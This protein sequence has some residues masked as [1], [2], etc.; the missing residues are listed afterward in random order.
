[1]AIQF[2]IQ[3]QPHYI[4][5]TCHGAFNKDSTLNM[6][7]SGL[8]ITE[9][10]VKKV[11]LID[12]RNLG[13]NPPDIFERFQ[14]AVEFV[15]IQKSANS[16]IPVCIIGSHPMIDPH[17]FGETVAVNRGGTFGVFT[18]FDEAIAW[19]EKTRTLKPEDFRN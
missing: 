16:H 5:L 4:H 11:L 9:K 6:Y 10:E 15:K 3:I 18:D 1:M 14:L 12:V 19:I 2:Q 13:G 7:K 8:E 17:K